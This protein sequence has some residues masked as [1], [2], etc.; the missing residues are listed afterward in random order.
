MN[1]SESFYKE[2]FQQQVLQINKQNA[3]HFDPPS[4]VTKHVQ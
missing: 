1:C 4:T 2:A 3:D